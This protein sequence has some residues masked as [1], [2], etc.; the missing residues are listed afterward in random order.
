MPTWLAIT[1][2]SVVAVAA[3]LMWAIDYTKKAHEIEKL[4]LE[5]E[6]LKREERKEQQK[7]SGLYIPSAAEVDRFNEMAR[8]WGGRAGGFGVEENDDNWEDRQRESL[9]APSFVALVF[10]TLGIILLVY[11]VL[12]LVI[13]TIELLQRIFMF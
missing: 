5:L 6:K 12:W 4:R 13:D 11:A 9:T 10:G 8:R 7:A 3:I 1:I 2:P